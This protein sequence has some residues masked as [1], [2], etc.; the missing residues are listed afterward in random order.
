MKR[1]ARPTP[2]TDPA[3]KTV[4]ADY[5]KLACGRVVASVAISYE[6]GR[7]PLLLLEKVFANI[8]SVHLGN[9]EV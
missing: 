6:R 8:V 5:T 4:A 2:I 7:S 9:E 3:G 1:G